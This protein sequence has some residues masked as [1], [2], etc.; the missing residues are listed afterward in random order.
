MQGF[1]SPWGYHVLLRH[2]RQALGG[3]PKTLMSSPKRR[4]LLASETGAPVAQLD[5]VTAYEAGGW[6]FE[7]SQARQNRTR[8]SKQPVNKMESDITLDISH[9]THDVFMHEALKEAAFAYEKDEVPVGAV[10][11]HESRVIA[12]A[13]NQ[14]ELL[15]DPTAHAE[16]IAITQAAAAL[17][18]WRLTGATIYVTL[19]PC[20]M[21]AGAMVLARIDKLV[22][23]TN[24][25]KAGACGTLYNIAA[26]TRLNHRLEII[27]GVLAEDCGRML[28]NFFAEKREQNNIA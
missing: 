26:D 27:P 2:L 3:L 7:P 25:P 5:R 22:Y 16:M 1:E 13:H 18:N 10:I 15:K 11:V 6:R 20:T 21:C 14:R 9:I 19:E 8:P 23:G 28:T 12:R 4:S 24:D 17:D